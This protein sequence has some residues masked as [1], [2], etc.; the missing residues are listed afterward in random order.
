MILI[1][2]TY[3]MARVEKGAGGEIS[4]KFSISCFSYLRE[5]PFW[6]IDSTIKRILLLN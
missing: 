3:H 4:E 1:I 5:T 2:I 6:C